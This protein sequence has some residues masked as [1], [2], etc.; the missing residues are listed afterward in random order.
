M[1]KE[2]TIRQ[3]LSDIIDVCMDMTSILNG[4]HFGTLFDKQSQID[5]IRE[6]EKKAREIMKKIKTKQYE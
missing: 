1:D 5:Y 2:N 4:I 3:D 6:T